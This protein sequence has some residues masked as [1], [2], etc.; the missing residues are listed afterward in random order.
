MRV[1]ATGGLG[2]SNQKFVSETLDAIHAREPITTLVHGCAAGAE[3]LADYWAGV[4]G[5]PV[6]LFVPDWQKFGEA[7][8]AVRNTVVIATRPDLVVLFPGD[9]ATR[10]CREQCVIA[11]LRVQEPAVAMS[12]R[13]GSSARKAPASKQRDEFSDISWSTFKVK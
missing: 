1:F 2:F 12:A 5:V 11:G 4:N 3:A 6:E 10:I 13:A 7:A 9:D 8:E